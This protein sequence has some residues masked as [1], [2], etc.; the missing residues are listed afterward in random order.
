MIKISQ[1]DYAPVLSTVN[2]ALMY[3]SNIYP[4][5]GITFCRRDIIYFFYSF[6][7]ESDP[8][9]IKALYL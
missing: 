1:A 2:M 6:Q 3:L 4:M 5:V 8:F 7:G 9:L